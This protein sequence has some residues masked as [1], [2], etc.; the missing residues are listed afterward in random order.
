MSNITLRQNLGNT[1][2]RSANVVVKGIGLSNIELDNNFNNINNEVELNTRNVASAYSQANS[3]FSAANNVAPQIAPAYNTANIALSTAIL[4]YNNSNTKFN[5]SGGIISGSVDVVGSVIIEGALTVSGNVT[6]INANNLSIQDNMI[7]LNEG[8]SG[9]VNP[10]LGFAGAYYDTE[11]HHCGFFRDAT[12]GVWKVF[13]NYKP[14]PDASIYIDTSNNTF[15]I[16]DFQANNVTFGKISTSSTELVLNLNSQ[17]FDGKSSSYYDSAISS[18]YS[19]ANTGVVQ[20]QSAFDQANNEPIAKSA[21]EQANTATTN[22]ANASYLSVGTVSAARLG[23]GT[24]NSSTYLAGDNVW[25]PI[26]SGATLAI[27]ESSNTNYY[28]GLSSSNSGSWLTAYV[29]PNKLSFN[30][31]LGWLGVNIDEPQTTLHVGGT[32]AIILPSGSDAQR[33]TGVNGMV[34]YSTS[35]NYIEMFANNT[36]SAI[37]SGSSEYYYPVREQFIATANQSIFV[38]DG[39]YIP[40]ELDVFYN[41]IKLRIGAE[42]NVSNGIDFTLATPAA[43]NALIEISGIGTYTSAGRDLTTPRREFFVATTNQTIF[44]VSGGYSPGMADVYYNGSK[45]VNGIDVDVSSGLSV[46]LTNPAANGAVVDVVALDSLTYLDVVKKSG[47]SMTGNL[48][49]PAFIGN[50]SSLTSLS[51]S[52]INASGTANSTTYLAGDAT[53]KQIDFSNINANNITSGTVNA[54][55]LGSGTANSTTYLAGDA[56]WKTIQGGATITNNVSTNANYYLG[57]SSGTSGSWTSAIVSS[58]KLYFNPSTG[59]LS[60]TIFNSLSDKTLKENINPVDHLILDQINP[61]EFTWKDSGKKSYGVIAQ[62]LEEILPE[63]VNEC[64]GIKS[65]EYN[66][67]IAILIK[68]VQELKTEIKTLKEELG[69]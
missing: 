40:G 15:R 5:S 17:Y 30:P 4:A 62:E 68:S 49:A 48:T 67:L 41:G 12:D 60:A 46:V 42:V 50:G 28:V 56:T 45:L 53:W 35:N 38:V 19:Q 26:V 24:A 57:M 11:Y 13:D 52:N 23:S 31:S 65:V 18:A 27:D 6:T 69:K 32:E 33:P 16:A 39:G 54:A 47:D 21:F 66:S 9:N 22:A 61:V 64:D 3:A 59:T 55:R 1:E 37:S 20:A 25:R 29:A 36:W 51:V 34:R 2:P 10:D 8:L 7:Y 44:N 43:N 58:T 63:L 14:E